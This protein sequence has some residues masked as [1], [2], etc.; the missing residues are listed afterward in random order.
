MDRELVLQEY[1]DILATDSV[2]ARN[3]IKKLD[4]KKDPFLLQCI[5]QTYLDESRFH[6]DG[7]PRKYVDLRKWRWA[8]DYIIKAFELDANCL[9]VIYTMGNV[10]KTYGQTDVAI[11]CFEKILKLGVR[12]EGLCQSQVNLSLAK[13]LVNDSKFELYR[14]YYS[15][16]P[17]LSKAHLASYKRGLKKGVGTIYQPLEKF[18][19]S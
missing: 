2:K 19:I 12:E 14:L 11:Y 1:R 4:Y 9:M 6:P 3:L 15:S 5:A 7:T 10:R 13:E 16:D 17:A 8:E 18:L